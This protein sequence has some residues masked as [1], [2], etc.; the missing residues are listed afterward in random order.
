ME[1]RLDHRVAD[2]LADRLGECDLD[3]VDA[4]AKPDKVG[5]LFGRDARG[6]F[7]HEHLAG[8]GGEQLREGNA[9]AQAERKNG[10]DSDLACRP[11]L[12]RLEP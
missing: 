3:Q 8:L 7:D 9:V 4:G 5:H 11:K 6:D 12:C 1:T 2:R 10:V